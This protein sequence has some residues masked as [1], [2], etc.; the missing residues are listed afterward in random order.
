MD[1]INYK[2]RVN[3]ESSLVHL[4]IKLIDYQHI[5]TDYI[6]LTYTDT[7]HSYRYERFEIGLLKE[8]YRD[9]YYCFMNNIDEI[10][11]IENFDEDDAVKILNNQYS[12]YS[13]VIQLCGEIMNNFPSLRTKN[14][15]IKV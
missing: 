4:K 1:C 15:N 9:G 11:D 12:N 7:N 10:E 6:S 3:L 5:Y 2:F 14:L 8:R 13:E